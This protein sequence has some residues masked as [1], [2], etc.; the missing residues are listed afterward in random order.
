MKGLA[1][2]LP[3]WILIGCTA[4]GPQYS[5]LEHTDSSGQHIVVYRYSQEVG[6][7]SGT[8]VPG[9]VE[10]DGKVIGKLPNNSFLVFNLPVGLFELSVTPMIDFHYADRHRMT[11]RDKVE[12]GETAFFRVVSVW[13]SGPWGE[14]CANIWEKVEGAEIAYTVIYPRPDWVQYF[15]LQRVPEAFASQQLMNLKLRRAN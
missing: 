9:R 7:N 2:F 15:C 1:A 3:C 5:P 14:G 6:G 13:G 12:K 8:W 10:L 11:L 4:T